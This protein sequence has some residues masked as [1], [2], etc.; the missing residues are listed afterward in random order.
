LRPAVRATLLA[1]P[2]LV[3]AQAGDAGVGGQLV[4]IAQSDPVLDRAAVRPHGLHD[5]QERHVE[6]QHLVFGMVG[7]PGNLVGREPRVDRVDHAATAGDA[8]VQLEVAIAVPRERGHPVAEAQLQRIER[9]GHLPGPAR[10]VGVAVAVDVALDAARH[11]R[12]VP[13]VPFGELEQPR[14]QQRLLL[15]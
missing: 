1:E 9:S 5:R 4:G 6:A 3:A 2:G 10:R 12:R 8:E 15:H 13:V 11:D 14:D 7:D